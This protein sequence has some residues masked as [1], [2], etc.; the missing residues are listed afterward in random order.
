ME[1]LNN[2]RTKFTYN[3]EK[4]TSIFVGNTSSAIEALE[5]GI[6]VLHLCPDIDIDLFSEKLLPNLKVT[7]LSKHLYAYKLQKKNSLIRFGNKDNN[8]NNFLLNEK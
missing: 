3:K 8:L 1:I 5:R 7:K 2:N 6:N 4:N